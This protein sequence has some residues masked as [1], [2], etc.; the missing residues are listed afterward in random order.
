MEVVR[1]LL[2]LRLTSLANTL[3]SRLRRLRQP[4]Y[5]FGTLA[6][7]AYFWFFFFRKT[8]AA[9]GNPQFAATFFGDGRAELGAGL[10]LSAFVLLMWVTP[11]D[12]P[13]LAFTEAEVAFLFPAP[14]SRAQLMHYKLIDG[15]MMALFGSLFF[16]L[17]SAGVRG[18]WPGAVR[19]LGAWWSLNA[20]LALH[21]TLSA[22]LIAKLS[23][24]GLRSVLRRTLLVVGAVALLVTAITVAIQAGPEKLAWLLWP[25]RLAV[26]PFLAP[27][28]ATWLPALGPAIGLV[29]LQYFLVHRLETPFEEASIARAQKTGE[30]LARMRSG[31]L[32]T[33][34]SKAQAK[35]GPFPLADRLPAEAALLWKNLM[36]SPPWLNR[37]VWFAAAAILVFGLTWLQRH[38]DFGG[39]KMAAVFGFI[40]MVFLVYVLVFGPQLARNDIRGDLLNADMLKAWPLPGWRIVLGSLLAPTVLLTAIAWLLLLA[41]AIGVEPPRGRIEWLTPQFRLIGGLSIA[42]IMPGLCAVQ[43]LVPNAGA[44]LFPAWAQNTRGT[45]G[46]MDVMGQRLIFFAGQFICLVLALLPAVLLAAATI[47]LTQWLIGLPAACALAVIPVTAVFVGELWLGVWLLG[48]RFERLDI[49]AELRP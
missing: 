28:F 20:N 36:A 37:K 5:L 26:R 18:N 7:I 21:Q 49:S 2:Y 3:R 16:T 14:L 30:T 45:H 17:M 12:Q 34:T 6:A 27:D 46:G 32:M 15:L 41:A 23:A 38:P 4:K 44:L 48:P 39:P 47:F 31:K 13:G 35:R 40:S 9:L 33:F 22:L 10:M 11:S 29:A 43:L 24:L 42:A 25:A 19:H 8:G 1:A